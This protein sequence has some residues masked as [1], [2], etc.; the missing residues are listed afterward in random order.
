MLSRGSGNYQMTQDMPLFRFGSSDG[1]HPRK[2]WRMLR[3]ISLVLLSCMVSPEAK[4]QVSTADAE[5]ALGKSSEEKGDYHAALEHLLRA[6]L[7]DPK[8]IKAH[9]AVGAI[10]GSWCGRDIDSNSAPEAGFCKLAVDEYEKV[11]ELDAAHEGALKKLAFIFYMKLQLNEAEVYYRKALDLNPNNPELLCGVSAIA[12]TRS[13]PEISPA[14][15]LKYMLPIGAPLIHSPF[16]HDIRRQNLSRVEEG[17]TLLKRA[18]KSRNNCVELLIYMSR[19]YT[20]RAEIQCGNSAAYKADR[21]A[22]AKWDQA[23]EKI[24]R[25]SGAHPSLECPP[26]PPPISNKGW[27]RQD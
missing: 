10:A 15:K 23:A 19:L 4:S 8:M 1:L 26:A 6:T 9:F 17:I 25:K 22:A 14:A 3:P 27:K 13:W 5:F 18:H 16:C 12:Y 21:K 24:W 11:L 7:L 20:I 2:I